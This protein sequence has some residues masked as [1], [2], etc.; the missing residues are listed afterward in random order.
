M[1]YC[2]PSQP[3]SIADFQRWGLP[4]VSADNDILFGIRRCSEVLHLENR[5]P[6]LRVL[7]TCTN[8]IR[9]I[10][11]YQWAQNKKVDG[12][13]DIPAQ[14]QNDHAIDA[15]RY[16]LVEAARYETGEANN[17]FRQKRGPIS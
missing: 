4:V 1:F 12:Y 7:S 14:N 5:V 2:D 17:G 13:I 15:L 11:E 9:E 10:R 8:L 3:Q 16:A 6:R